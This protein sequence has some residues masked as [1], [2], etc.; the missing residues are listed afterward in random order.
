M[1]KFGSVQQPVRQKFF[2]TAS[3]S[4]HYAALQPMADG[5]SNIIQNVSF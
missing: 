5:G 3:V 1:A 2:V 4:P